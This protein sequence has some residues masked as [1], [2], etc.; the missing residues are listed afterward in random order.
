[1]PILQSETPQVVLAGDFATVV[2]SAGEPV[3]VTRDTDGQ[4]RFFA[5]R[6]Q[7]I[8]VNFHVAPDA[9]LRLTDQALAADFLSANSRNVQLV[10][11]SGCTQVRLHCLVET[12]STSENTPKLVAKYST[13]HSTDPAD[14]LDVGSSEVSTTLFS[15]GHKTSGWVTITSDAIADDLYV[16]VIQVG[17]DG[18]SDPDVSGVVVEF[19]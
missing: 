2:T 9:S 14:Y 7:S 3:E 5:P 15:T 10:D 11:C 13:T 19:R 17:G 6:S 18:T 8:R 1:M 4:L 12:A 16:S